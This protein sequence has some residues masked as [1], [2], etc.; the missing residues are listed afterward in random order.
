MNTR[1][2][3]FLLVTL[4]AV[5]T[6]SLAACGTFKKLVGSP[7]TVEELRPATTNNYPTIITN[8][9]QRPAATNEDG[10]V[11]PPGTVV[12]VVTNIVPVVQPAIFFTN[13][14]VAPGVK[15]GIATADSLASASGIPWAHTAATGVLAALTI[16]LTWSNNR[17]KKKLQTSIADHTQTADALGT[18]QDVAKTLVENFEQLRTVALT[19]PGYT[20]AIDDKVMTAVQ[21]AQQI[22]GVKSE[23][24]NLVD[25]HTPTTIPGA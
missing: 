19:I 12:T 24:N 20:R 9:V 25:E 2:F 3:P 23:I 18:A 10:S 8:I 6:L 5:A 4:L 16:F 11:T 1:K 13:L 22:A 17:D 7:G 15:G 14:V 21:V